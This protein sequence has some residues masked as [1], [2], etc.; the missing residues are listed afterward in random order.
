MMNSTIDEVYSALTHSFRGDLLRPD[1]V[2]YSSARRLW[3]GMID[4]NPGLI[5]RCADVTDV[6]AAVRAARE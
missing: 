5:A 2:G 6:Q 1:T 4:R 3:N